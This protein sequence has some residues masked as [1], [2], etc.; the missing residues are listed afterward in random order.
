MAVIKTIR[1]AIDV[2]SLFE[3]PV[4]GSNYLYFQ[5]DAY[6]KDTLAPLYDIGLI[7]NT[8]GSVISNTF[9]YSG[10]GQ[11]AYDKRISGILQ[12]NGETTHVRNNLFK[13]VDDYRNNLDIAPFVSMDTN[14]RIKPVQYFTDGN[15]NV[16]IS[17]YNYNDATVA[18]AQTYAYSYPSYWTKINTS[19]KD[20]AISGYLSNK[21]KW[22]SGSGNYG[23]S[24]PP[25]ANFATQATVSGSYGSSSW[26]V[27]RNPVT[28]NLVW[29]SQVYYL[30]QTPGA[31]IG[32]S[33][34]TA[35]SASPVA[36][37]P[38][39]C[40][41]TNYTGQLVGVSK[42]DFNTIQIHLSVTS[43]GVNTI[44]KYNDASNTYSTLNSFVASPTAAGAGTTGT[45]NL[46]TSTIMAGLNFTTST[47]GFIFTATNY[48]STFSGTAT[49]SGSVLTV[50]SST[51]GFNPIAAGMTI[52]QIAVNL[53]TGAAIGATIAAGAVYTGTIITSFGQG[54]NQGG[55]RVASFGGYI[56]KF[57]S[58]T[59]TDTS[60]A[61]TLGFYIPYVDKN[62][63]FH[64]LYY[65]WNQSTDNFTRV[66]DITMVY[67]GTT[68]GAVWSYDTFSLSSLNSTYGMQRAW[69]TET[70]VSSST[71]FL[72]FMQLH[73][74]GGLF[75]GSATLRTF[76]V[77]TIDTSTYK[78]LTYY[79]KIEVPATPK[80]IVWLSDDRTILGIFCHANFYVYTF[81]YASGWTQTG[82]F[83][84]QFNAVG[85]DNTG[86]IWAQDTGPGWG[87]L[88]LLTLNVPVSIVVTSDATSYNF[89][90]TTV[91][92]NITVNA[93]NYDGSR[94][95]TS[96]KLVIDGGA[97]TFAGSNLT[98]TVTTS[99]SGDTVVPVTITGG[100]VSNIIASA[101]VS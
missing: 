53:A 1:N 83:P 61:T 4:P 52:T 73:G 85:R 69:Y 84:F 19:A 46:S 21:Q 58:K 65:R 88:H 30:H 70:F 77:Y 3:D 64:P 23:T 79:G 48:T 32:G 92:A 55:D 87:R 44:Y 13:T 68:Q 5:T 25:H 24:N 93:Y 7:Y 89:A 47:W 22:D 101:V 28:N 56:P 26:P 38:S 42:L 78:T 49:V 66:T 31:L 36:Q 45:Y 75:D 99:A 29:I 80:N 35:F 60:T 97:M 17:S 98:K 34:I 74:A 2:N 8:N 40:Q 96:V 59:F 82:N 43:D 51:A 10:V 39:N 67:P 50:T 62:G 20:L 12:L 41:N 81:S 15:N 100:G 71:R 6:T 37:S 18:G 91:S 95:A 63:G 90:G 16:V 94:I 27:Y 54:T 9:G 57:A 11:T 33:H 14:Y 86:R 76:P 72:I